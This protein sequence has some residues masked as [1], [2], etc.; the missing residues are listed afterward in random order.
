[1][2]DL[3]KGEAMI[4]AGYSV[5]ASQHPARVESSDGFKH[6]MM[7][8][9]SE[10]GKAYQSMLK[11]IETRDMSKETTD[12]LL[13]GIETLSKAWE[14]FLPKE[15]QVSNDDDLTRVF[16]RVIDIPSPDNTNE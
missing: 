8:V 15:K 5:K 11:E 16:A 2:E 9:A 3:T 12:T 1:M 6:A 4:K 10:T 13:K 7:I 14:R